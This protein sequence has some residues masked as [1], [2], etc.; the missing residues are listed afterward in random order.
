M[1]WCTPI[2][3]LLLAL[4]ARV[5]FLNLTNPFGGKKTEAKEKPS[6]NSVADKLRAAFTGRKKAV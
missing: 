5:E 6:A 1:A 2:P 3:E 4:D